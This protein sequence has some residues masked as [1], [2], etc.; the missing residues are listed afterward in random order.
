MRQKPATRTLVSVTALVT[1]LLGVTTASLAGASAAVAVPEPAAKQTVA[2]GPVSVLAV[3]NLGLTTVEAANVQNWLK[4][5]WGYT[6]PIDGRLGTES[7][8]AFQRFLRAEWGYTGP[9]DGKVQGATVVTLQRFLAAEWG[10][11]VVDGIIGVETRAA[12]KRFA[13]GI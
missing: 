10:L 2:S 6:G 8:R 4:R 9:L 13:N 12:F 1:A 11:P 7:W 5:Y 3:N